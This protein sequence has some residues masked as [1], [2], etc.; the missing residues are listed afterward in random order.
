MSIFELAW[1]PHSVPMVSTTFL[2]STWVR[3]FLPEN[4]LRYVRKHASNNPILRALL[5]ALMLFHCR[6]RY[7]WRRWQKGLLQ[8]KLMPRNFC[9]KLDDRK[10]SHYCIFLYVCATGKVCHALQLVAICRCKH[11][12]SW[13]RRETDSMWKVK[14]C[15]SEMAL[16]DFY[17]RYVHGHYITVH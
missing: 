15:S 6:S 9:Q 4:C 5:V 3:L 17:L 11:I 13:C 2:I 10:R 1:E 8:L 12:Y 14:H 16:H 7:F